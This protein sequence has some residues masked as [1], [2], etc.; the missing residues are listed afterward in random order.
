MYIYKFTIEYYDESNETKLSAEGIMASTT[1]EQV[2]ARLAQYYGGD[3]LIFNLSLE[4]LDD[5]V[6]GKIVY[7]EL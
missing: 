4:V 6:E 1:Y 3:E 7:N 5:I 2:V